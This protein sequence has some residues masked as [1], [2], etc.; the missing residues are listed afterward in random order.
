MQF[1]DDTD[2]SLSYDQ[3]TI[4]QTF[5]MLS[6]IETDTGLC[7]SYEKTTMYRV[8]S[9][10]NT[11]AKLITPKKVNWSNNYINTLGIN[12]YNDSEQRDIN[13]SQVINKMKV[14]SSLWYYRNMSHTGRVYNY[15]YTYDAI[16][17]LQ[18][19]GFTNTQ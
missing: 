12:L 10:A 13:I 15:Q 4:T 3:E 5:S 6:G 16:V 14:V 19:A 18:N 1:A 8:G 17:C 11:N 2:L 7:I 9:L